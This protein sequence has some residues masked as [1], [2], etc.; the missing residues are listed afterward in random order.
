MVFLPEIACGYVG[1]GN[2]RMTEELRPGWDELKKD[3][4]EIADYFGEEIDYIAPIVRGG[5]PLGVYISH[6]LDIPVR[7]INANHYQKRKRQGSVDISGMHL[8]DIGKNDTVLVF[9]DVVE[10]GD[11]LREVTRSIENIKRIPVEVKT[12]SIHVKPERDINPDYWRT[13][14]DKWVVYPWEE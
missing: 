7:A 1:Y 13:E 3:A 11:T 8:S 14:T 12:A 9:D 4:G 10:T 2:G 6:L 5:M